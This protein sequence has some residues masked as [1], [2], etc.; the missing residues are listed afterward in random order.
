MNIDRL[1]EHGE[2]AGEFADT[3][4]DRAIRIDKLGSRR[5]GI[6]MFI[7]KSHQILESP[8]LH[9]GIA[10][11]QQGI[12]SPA[13]ADPGIVR[14]DIAHIGG[15]ADQL[16][17]GEFFFNHFRTSIGRAI[18]YDDD[19]KMNSLGVVINGLQASAQQFFR[20]VTGHNNRYIQFKLDSIVF[21]LF[22]L[23]GF[24]Y[25]LLTGS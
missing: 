21:E 3:M 9:R 1:Q 20:I 7:H 16:G 8:G 6:W 4:L 12:T 23:S 18:V 11:K 2:H 15:I 25:V 19:F 24:F 10:V 13:S 17:L 5:R 14:P 22:F